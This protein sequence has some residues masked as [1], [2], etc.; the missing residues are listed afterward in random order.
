MSETLY[1]KV[2]RKYVAVSEF[3][4]SLSFSKGAHL[5]ICDPGSTIKKHN[6]E[7]S[8]A[9][10]IAAGIIAEDAIAEVIVKSTDLRPSSTP[11]TDEQCN[12]WAALSDA[13]GES[14]HL[15]EW[16]S[17]RLAAQAAVTALIKESDKLMQNESVRKAYDHFILMC[18]LAK[19]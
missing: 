12:A 19:E 13:F 7:P 5:I 3:E 15:L 17:P 16:P 11:L 10:L 14:R 8:Y 18:K 6:I 2:G 9:P 1:K 4:H